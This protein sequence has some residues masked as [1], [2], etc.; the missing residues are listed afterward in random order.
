MLT[1]PLYDFTLLHLVRN[2]FELANV[3]IATMVSAP[4]TLVI[5]NF[6]TPN[7]ASPFYTTDRRPMASQSAPACDRNASIPALLVWG[8]HETLQF[9]TYLPL[10]RRQLLTCKARIL[11][12]P[13]A[14]LGWDFRIPEQA[15]AGGETISVALGRAVQ[16]SLLGVLANV[17]E[18]F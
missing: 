3:P 12:D 6:L 7:G 15:L 1:R 8:R 17:N 4:M 11:L 2:A 16:R 9:C 13:L 10:P 18:A 14:G 5:P